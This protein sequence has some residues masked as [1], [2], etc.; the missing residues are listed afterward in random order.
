MRRSLHVLL[1]LGLAAGFTGLATSD[2]AA[3]TFPREAPPRAVF[4]VVVRL[5]DQLADELSTL[6]EDIDVEL[7]DERGTAL[8]AQADRTLAQIHHLQKSARSGASPEHLRQH[9]AEL[10]QNLHRFLDMTAALGPDGNFLRESASRIHDLDHQLMKLLVPPPSP[11]G[12]APVPVGPER[13]ERIG[14][15]RAQPIRT[16][17]E[18]AQ[19]LNVDTQATL[20][21]ENPAGLE[22]INRVAQ[23]TE[24]TQQLQRD[25]EEGRGPEDLQGAFRNLEQ[26]WGL[27]VNALDAPTS[28][29][30]RDLLDRAQRL[31]TL[32]ENLH[33]QIRSEGERLPL[34]EQP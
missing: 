5:T 26:A 27:A 19:A 13:P 12:P 21:R 3:Q 10:A 18:V 22:A 34:R 2:V 11:G 25:L 9:A 1:A 17:A 20:R 15:V 14:E 30:D 7:P 8:A 23:F 16:L 29:A 4:P 32:F 31:G 28:G 24:A 33:R 6:R